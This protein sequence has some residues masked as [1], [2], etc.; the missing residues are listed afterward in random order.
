MLWISLGY[1]AH[2]ARIYDVATIGGLTVALTH[3]YQGGDLADVIN[4]GSLR[5]DLVRILQLAFDFC[6]GMIHA[7][8]YGLLAHRDIKPRNCLLDGELGDS[9]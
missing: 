6:E 4:K 5:N 2:I 9:R 1:H 7:R 3:Y 8:N